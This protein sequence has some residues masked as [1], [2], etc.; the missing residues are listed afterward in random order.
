MSLGT[1]TMAT[2]RLRGLWRA[3]I[4]VELSKAPGHFNALCRS[5]GVNAPDAM[6]RL[7]KKLQREGLVIRSAE[8]GFNKTSWHLATTAQPHVIAAYALIA[9]AAQ[10]RADRE[11][12]EVEF[13]RSKPVI[14]AEHID[15][16][17]IADAQ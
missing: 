15:T 8:P 11:L 14:F 13:K 2:E 7:L 16:G 10:R 9:E 17:K 3:R 1:T 4:L 6:A 12:E 5:V